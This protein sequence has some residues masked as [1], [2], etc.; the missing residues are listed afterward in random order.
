[1][2]KRSVSI[3]LVILMVFS[4]LPISTFAVEKV[5]DNVSTVENAEENLPIE[6]DED[7]PAV[8]NAEEDLLTEPIDV[9]QKEILET[10][11]VFEADPKS[12]Q[13]EDVFEKAAPIE[14]EE[15]GITQNSNIDG[16]ITIDE[17]FMPGNLQNMVE[18]TG[19]TEASQVIELY[20]T[21]N[22][23]FNDTDIAYLNTLSNLTVLDVAETVTVGDVGDSFF[24][25]QD[26]LTTV[27]FPAKTFGGWAFSNCDELSSVSLPLAITFGYG[28][29]EFCYK[30]RSV[31]LPLAT[32]FGSAFQFCKVLSSI[33][34]PKATTLGASF[35]GCESLTTVNLPSAITF[36]NEAFSHCRA[37]ST[38]SLPSTTTFGNAAFYECD[39]LI[40][41]DL[42]SA[43]TFGEYAIAYCDSLSRLSLPVATTFGKAAF[44]NSDALISVDLPASTTFGTR[45]FYDCDALKRVKLVSATSFASDMYFDINQDIT[46]TLGINIPAANSS[47][48]SSY[49]PANHTAV[50]KVPEAQ[51]VAYDEADGSIDNMWYGWT[52]E[53][54]QTDTIETTYQTHIENIGWQD[55]V[56][57]GEMG[58]T[59][60]EALRLEA[61][62]I[63]VDKQEKDLGIEY[64]THVQNIGW[65]EWKS[66]GTMNGTTGKSL[67]LEAIRIQLTGTDADNYDI[68]YQVYSENFGWMGWA[69]NGESAGTEGLAYRLEAIKIEV[70]PK[71]DPAPGNTDQP[72]VKN[73]YCQYQ[74]HIQNSSWQGW[75]SK[76][77]ISGTTGQSLRL[78]A[79]NIKTNDSEN[80]GVEY[81][82]YVHNSGWQGW[83]SNG[84][85]SGT[86]GKALQLEA[87]QIQLTGDHADI[88]DIY[89][90]VHVENYGWLGWAKNGESAGTDGF[91]YR[92]E[93]IKIVVI[94]K[95]SA[96]PGST[97]DSFIIK[98]V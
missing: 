81:Q 34:L 27:E 10:E 59:T 64:Q 23:E 1:M 70:V 28:T 98:D 87:I 66:N 19:I 45:A 2:Y 62:K 72:C 63:E 48:F 17:D 21:S 54:M 85:T 95:E 42:P 8:E 83:K 11:A 78:E 67:R 55:A 5:E 51:M 38:I 43:T 69:K 65:Q 40:T 47:T 71:D 96:A 68:Y 97:V 33:S 76:G 20:V 84:E 75:Q 82:T 15:K 12:N 31:D 37:L 9:P 36:G 92:L 56:S 80:V 77:A 93:A 13:K 88:Y 41:I 79:I 30:L 52:I 90:Q 39:A 58:G 94:L 61:I 49:D 29:F 25:N 57:N 14:A 89:Y 86:T 22:G 3:L 73:V 53:S 26:K 4:V 91:G 6:E 44:A 18:L 60:G 16:I 24:Y 50:V 46:M 7:V 32:T 35:R 74:S